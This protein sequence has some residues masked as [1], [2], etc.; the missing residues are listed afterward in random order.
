MRRR[1]RRHRLFAHLYFLQRVWEPLGL[2]RH[3]RGIA[4]GMRGA[5]LEIGVGTGFS[6]PYYAAAPL[7]ASDPNA[8]MLRKARRRARRLGM[9][10]SFVAARGEQ[11]PFRDGAFDT[12]VSEA[13]LCSVGSPEAVIAEVRRALAP[14]GRLRC[15]EHGLATRPAMAAVQRAIAPAWARLFGGC[16][17][18]RDVIGPLTGS[19]LEADRLIRCSGGS[20]VRATMRN[21]V[22]EPVPEAHLL[23]VERG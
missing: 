12:V 4:R 9:A 18:D 10:T 21:A 22:A 11:L 13:V 14:G 20:V 17:L 15:V 23:R 6:L 7:V 19:G 1:P 5:T 8:T 16:R 2:A 3:R